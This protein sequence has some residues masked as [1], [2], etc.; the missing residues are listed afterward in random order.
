MKL[1]WNNNRFEVQFTDFQNDLDAVKTAGFR[2]SGPPEWIWFAP[3]PGIKALD[4]LRKIQSNLQITELALQ[5]YKSLTQKFEQKQNLRKQFK[6]AQ[7]QA[8]KTEPASIKDM[9]F[10][11][12]LQFWCAIVKPPTEIEFIPYVR[13]PYP[14]EKCLLCDAPLWPPFEDGRSFC[15]YCEKQNE[16]NP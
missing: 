5:H 4:R 1:V 6:Q 10:D 12:E 2:T 9:Y 3:A 8:K 15:M 7:K 11:E 13:P 16:N 14:E